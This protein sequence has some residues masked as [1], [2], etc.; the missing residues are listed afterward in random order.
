M[1][2]NE[3]SFKA[4]R[5]ADAVEHAAAEMNDLALRHTRA[6]R[7]TGQVAPLGWFAKRIERPENLWR[8]GLG[9]WAPSWFRIRSS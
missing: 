5:L 8:G 2:I 3:L 1:P 7:D 9:G 4:H 6:P